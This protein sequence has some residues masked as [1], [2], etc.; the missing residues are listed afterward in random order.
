MGMF[1]CCGGGG[2]ASDQGMVKRILNEHF[3]VY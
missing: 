3:N 1:G 2:G